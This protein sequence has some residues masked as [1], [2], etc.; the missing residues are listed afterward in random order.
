MPADAS[1]YAIL[2]VEPGADWSEVERAY[3]QLIKVHHPDL[4]GG[5][6][7]RATEI[8][9]AY[10]ELKRVRDTK[11]AL[12]LADDDPVGRPR[13]GWLWGMV[14]GA[15]L[16]GVLIAVIGPLKPPRTERPVALAHEAAGDPMD[17]DLSAAA[18][19]RSIREATRIF[20]TRDEMA[21]AGASRDCHRRL[22]AKPSLE[23]LDR[24]AAFD[25]AVVQLLDRDPLRSQGPFGELAVTSRQLSAGTILSN[26]S[27]AVDSRLDR[28]RLHVELAL[29][30]RIPLP[31]VPPQTAPV[32]DAA[33]D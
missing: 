4:S 15:A 29:V 25:D 26:D 5:D 16:V 20:R 31:P 3:K 9:H 32:N 28:I 18:I 8:I 13:R 33:V 27:L 6:A 17:S 30:P 14:S 11:G 12:V 22:R 1:A 23:Q 24:C 19:D 10:R 21:L 2:G 7:H